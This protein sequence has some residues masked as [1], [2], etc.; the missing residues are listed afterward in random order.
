[1]NRPNEAAMKPKN[2]RIAAI[3][4]VSTPRIEENLAAAGAL[5]ADAVAQGAGLVAL[6]EYFPI[7]ALADADKIAAGERDGV[8]PVQEFLAATA[9]RHGVWL[10]GGSLPFQSGV[11]GK[12]LNTCLVHDP[13][14]A[15]AARYD[16]IHLF[17]FR[18]GRERYDEGALIV[19]GRV[20]VTFDAPFGR[21]GLSICYDLRFPELFRALGNVD[22][23]TLPAAF[24]ETTGRAHWEILLRARAI[25]NQCYVLAAA[26]GGVHEN[27]RETHGDS[28]LID[29]WGE[30]IARRAKGEGIV[31]GE[32]DH[33]RIAEVRASL[34]ALDPR[35]GLYF[36]TDEKIM[37][38]GRL[39]MSKM[40]MG[41]LM[42]SDA[43]LRPRPICRNICGE[44]GKLLLSP[45]QNREIAKFIYTYCSALDSEGGFFHLLRIRE[46]LCLVDKFPEMQ[47]LVDK[48]SE[49]DS[50]R[51]CA[52]SECTAG[53]AGFP[54]RAG[55]L[56]LIPA[57]PGFPPV[58]WL[59][60]HDPAPNSRA[61]DTR[62]Q[63]IPFLFRK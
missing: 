53:S 41:L 63:V 43:R 8:G 12:V 32:L 24:T 33:A 34:P 13:S 7:M 27:R 4:M 58:E 62:D 28:M 56:R 15:R 17:G 6:P 60:R 57:R 44:T 49:P 16:K 45:R 31:I 19:P 18:N 46:W 40:A 10:V 11:S 21:V 37:T 61:P 55:G 2:V 47:P 29:P 42:A 51:P 35:V 5:I 38:G 48:S 30:V 54:R 14:G 20:P 52:V 59:C 9:R 36:Q 39:K 26:Q 22:L 1:M 3:Q 23:L 50:F 25:E